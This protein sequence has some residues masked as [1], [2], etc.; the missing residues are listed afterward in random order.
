MKPVISRHV[1]E[2]MKQ[3]GATK[4]EVDKTLESGAARSAKGNK[5]SSRLRFD[6]NGL[7][8]VTGKQYRYK[9]VEVLYAIE[10]NTITVVTV[11]VYYSDEEES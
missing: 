1:Q 8:P 4:D 7:S 3:R 11:K 5:K 10:D 9:T 2:R 6:F